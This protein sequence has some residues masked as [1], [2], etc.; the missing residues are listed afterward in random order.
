M[1][2]V[3]AARAASGLPCSA[4]G[5]RPR[6]AAARVEP[7]ERVRVSLVLDADQAGGVLGVRLG[8]GHDDRQRL[9]AEP[10]AGVLQHAQLLTGRG[11]DRGPRL[12]VAVGQPD[13]VVSGEHE[14]HAGGLAGVGRV[15]VP[16][17]SRG[18]R[19]VGCRRVRQVRRPALAA[20]PGAASDLVRPV[21]PG[22]RLSDQLAGTPGG[23]AP[24]RRS[25]ARAHR[26]PAA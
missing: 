11:L 16:D 6:L 1:T 24:R 15:D 10:D 14:Q 20:V 5:P 18:D 7:G 19:S 21:H 3:A 9:A 2:A 25:R 13:S 22:G 4:T 8:V 12:D 17:S 26:S 23:R